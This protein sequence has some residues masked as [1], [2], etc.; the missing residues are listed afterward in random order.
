[1][2]T[3]PAAIS[4]EED[5][6]SLQESSPKERLGNFCEAVRLFKMFTKSLLLNAE[7]LSWVSEVFTVRA[8]T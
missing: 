3:L 4:Q 6:G 5:P 2:A 1:M 8:Q 7:G